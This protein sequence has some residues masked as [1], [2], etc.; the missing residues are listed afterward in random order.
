VG[1]RNAEA[2]PLIQKEADPASKLE[3]LFA[4]CIFAFRSCAPSFL[5]H[6]LLDIKYDHSG[7]ACDH[8]RNDGARILPPGAELRTVVTP[9]LA[10]A[11]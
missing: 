2:E 9:P 11:P 4:H 5:P 8:P 6:A 1:W 10:Q 7:F 3:S